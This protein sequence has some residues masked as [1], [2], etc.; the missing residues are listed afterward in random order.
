MNGEEIAVKTNTYVSIEQLCDTLCA[1]LEGGSTYWCASCIPERYPEGIEW[2]HEAIAMCVPFEFG[3]FEDTERTKVDNS[4]QR[5][6]DALQYMADLYPHEFASMVDDNGDA[7][8][9]DLL[10]QIIC[11]GEVVYG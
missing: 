1:A 6:S 8:T 10:F 5:M 4:K 7:N 3:A 2:A 11:F 9:G